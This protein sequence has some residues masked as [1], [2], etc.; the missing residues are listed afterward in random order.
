MFLCLNADK[1]DLFKNAILQ[2]VVTSLH[3]H[4]GPTHNATSGSLPHTHTHTQ[5]HHHK[6]IKQF[7]ASPLFSHTEFLY[8]SKFNVRVIKHVLLH[9]HFL[10]AV[11]SNTVN[12]HGGVMEV[13]HVWPAANYHQALVHHKSLCLS[14]THTRAHTSFKTP[15]TPSAV[16]SVITMTTRQPTNNLLR[17][18][19]VFPVFGRSKVRRVSFNDPVNANSLWR[20]GLIWTGY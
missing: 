16:T 7:V 3:S 12:K 10:N 17:C 2:S 5:S 4:Q 14:H 11:T 15:E 20:H 18:S 19:Q 9:V 1:S 8:S 13:H 6:N